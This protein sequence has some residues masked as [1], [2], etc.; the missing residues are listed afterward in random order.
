MLTLS[1]STTTPSSLSLLSAGEK[2]SGFVLHA[3]FFLAALGFITAGAH[4]LWPSRIPYAAGVH[5]WAVGAIGV[6]TLAMM[7]RATLGHS[8][9]AL[10]ASKGMQFAYLCVVAALIARVAMA[11]APEFAMPLLI[12]ASGAWI[13][14]FAAFLAVYG[15]M[16]P[17][18]ADL[19][20][21]SASTSPSA[22]SATS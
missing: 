6:M 5:V 3:G 13:L 2:L 18:E 7:T 8:G 16:S 1:R 12:V 17:A 4:A 21:S 19:S 20:R 11:L 9:R 15:P 10:V 22:S 14:A